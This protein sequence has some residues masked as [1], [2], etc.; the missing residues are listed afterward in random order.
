MNGQWSFIDHLAAVPTIIGTAP[1]WN[2][3]LAVCVLALIAITA[4]V[5]IG[6]DIAVELRGE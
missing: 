3:D 4:Y 6:R 2:S 5:Q 1:A